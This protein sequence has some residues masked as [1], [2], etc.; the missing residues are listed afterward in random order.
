M[1]YP[2][3]GRWY[4]RRWSTDARPRASPGWGGT[5]RSKT[6]RS[7]V[8]APAPAAT[9]LCAAALDPNHAGRLGNPS[10]PP[11]IFIGLTPALLGLAAMCVRNGLVGRHTHHIGR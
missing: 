7:G 1:F 10:A 9:S 2:F 4:L 8:I 3:L 6:S 5:H 11:Y